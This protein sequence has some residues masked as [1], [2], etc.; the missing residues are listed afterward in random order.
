[1]LEP[2][3]ASRKDQKELQ[4]ALSSCMF[5]EKEQALEKPFPSTACCRPLKHG[6]A[7]TWDPIERH[8]EMF[9][10]TESVFGPPEQVNRPWVMEDKVSKLS[11]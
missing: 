4:I 2:D 3:S 5:T 6:I 1:M 7:R 8:P 11:R 10:R 9:V